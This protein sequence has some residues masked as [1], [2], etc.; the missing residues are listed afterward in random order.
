VKSLVVLHGGSVTAKSKGLGTGSEFTIALPLFSTPDEWQG[1]CE[2]PAVEAA[3]QGLRV[4][5]VDD[6]VDAAQ[7]LGLLLES[8]GTNVHVEHHPVRALECAR[9]FAPDV[10][11]LD[12]G[13]P[14]MDGNELARRLRQLPQ[15]RDAVLIAVT[16]YG[17]PQDRD[18]ALAAGFDH[19][20]V[21]PIDSAKLV[22]MLADISSHESPAPVIL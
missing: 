1:R 20:F 21:K 5:L 8:N 22:A 7:I 18:A 17:Q 11:L 12:I 9:T 10:C 19:H 6:N 15:T 4:L 3:K 2:A 13:L 14:E 16:G